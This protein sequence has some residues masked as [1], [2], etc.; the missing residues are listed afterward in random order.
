MEPGQLELGEAVPL[1]TWLQGE[2]K[3]TQVPKEEGNHNEVQ[4]IS[5][6]RK[7]TVAYAV[8]QLLQRAFTSAPFSAA[9]ISIDNFVVRT[10]KRSVDSDS[11]LLSAASSIADISGVD[12]ISEGLSLTIIE[13][14]YVNNILNEGE[15]GGAG[16][17]LDVSISPLQLPPVSSS[18]AV[19][20]IDERSICHHFGLLL[21]QLYSNLDPIPESL[22]G[23]GPIFKSGVQLGDDDAGD[24]AHEP[25]KKKTAITTYSALRDIKT[26]PSIIE[27]IQNLVDSKCD[28]PLNPENICSSMKEA[29][30]DLHLLLH[31]PSRFLF[32]RK[33]FECGGSAQLQIR[34]NRLYGREKEVSLLSDAF[35]RVSADGNEAFFIGGF[36]GS[37]KTRLVETVM[38][39][40]E[41]SGGY[42]VKLKFDQVKGSPLLELITA[43]NG[44]CSL[45]RKKQSPQE[46]QTIISQLT[47]S[48][49]SDLTVLGR[50][51]PNVYNLLPQGQLKEAREHGGERMNFQSV[52]FILRQFMRV[53]SSQSPVML[54]LDDLQV[55]SSF[56]MCRNLRL[57]WYLLLSLTYQNLCTLKWSDSTVLDVIHDILS[58]KTDARCFFVGSYRSNEV[59]SDHA[60]FGLMDDLETSKV[61][62][63]KLNLD[64]I[65]IDD[66]NTLISD[67]LC[68]FPRNTR[69]LST[70]IH[71]KTQ[72]S[73][74]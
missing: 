35:N 43:F 24:G 47:E 18:S 29:C 39:L 41:V 57:F 54:F 2:K 9:K 25:A 60:I 15:E 11:E 50:L 64:G 61:S 16:S 33:Q 38:K 19:E 17:F 48:V 26:P 66:V 67:A 4:K 51:L 55:S 42:V 27:L 46:L 22:L 73:K 12:M 7:T 5:I 28:K 68:A 63:Q 13:P 58:E 21:Y 45:I 65:E 23:T 10:K 1:Q 37:G 31:Q 34:Q 74:S 36:S 72:G 32:T 8:A 14:S 6:V 30:D 69:R 49:G 59:S 20:Q 56:C 70:I 52:C 71:E 62:A 40:V 53:V 3:E 44:L